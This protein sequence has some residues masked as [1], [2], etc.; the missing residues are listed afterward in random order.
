MSNPIKSSQLTLHVTIRVAP[1]N[2][3]PFL[4]ALRPCW[5]GVVNEPE[6]VFFDVFHDSANPGTFRFVECWTKDEKWFR[7]VQLKRSYYEPYNT[8][9]AQMWLVPRELQ[10]MDRVE[11]W[12]F[13]SDGYL[14]GSVKD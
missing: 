6:C 3:K 11:G 4:E 12:S 13:A 8:I 5:Q 1:E 10:F 14:A 9:T 2:I 7:E